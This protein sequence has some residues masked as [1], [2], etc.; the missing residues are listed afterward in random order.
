MKHQ[1]IVADRT[2]SEILQSNPP[3]LFYP[4]TPA[5]KK[6]VSY[7]YV[8]PLGSIHTDPVPGQLLSIEVLRDILL[9]NLLGRTIQKG[10]TK[11]RGQALEAMVKH[12]LGYQESSQDL[13][14]GGYPDIRHQVLEVKV[15]DSP[16]VD[17]G[18]YSPQNVEQI[19]DCPGITTAD[20]RYLIALTDGDSGV[21][22]GI[23]LCPGSRLGDKFA[24]VSATSVKYQRSIPM[25]FFDHFDGQSVANP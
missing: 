22:E 23:V 20:V 16:T 18:L 24:Y 10:A 6:W 3:L 1:L 21:I 8:R 4:D 7:E 5:L 19:P 17:L 2:R 13:L 11:N 9:P 15:Q 14:S 25:S 12:Y